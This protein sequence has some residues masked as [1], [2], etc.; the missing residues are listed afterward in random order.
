M[1]DIVRQVQ[2]LAAAADEAGKK[3]IVEQLRDLSFSVEGGGS[4]VQRITYRVRYFLFL[5]L[6]FFAL[7][8]W[9]L[10]LQCLGSLDG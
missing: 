7:I 6:F 1:E 5:F 8:S 10:G 3:K 9:D 2:V 4:V